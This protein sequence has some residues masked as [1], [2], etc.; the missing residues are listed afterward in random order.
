MKGMRLGPCNRTGDRWRVYPDLDTTVGELA[1]ALA[2]YPITCVVDEQGAVCL[3][4]IG[5]T[6]DGAPKMDAL[7]GALWGPDNP[8]TL[9]D[10]SGLYPKLRRV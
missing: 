9:V 8:A 3:Q 4:M 5:E 1:L 6:D 7:A 10:E 2:A